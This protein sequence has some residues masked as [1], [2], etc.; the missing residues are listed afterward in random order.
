MTARL[1][2]LMGIPP[3]H[4]RRGPR[5]PRRSSHSGAS[6]LRRSVG[7]RAA[8]TVRAAWKRARE[9]AR[10]AAN[11]WARKRFSSASDFP[12]KS[13]I[14]VKPSEPRKRRIALS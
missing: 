9:S 10:M 6:G 2:N 8:S 12:A 11:A 7:Q 14:A 1:A 3:L 4:E 13:L 5:G